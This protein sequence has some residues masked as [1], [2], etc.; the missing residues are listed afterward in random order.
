MEDTTPIEIR[1][2]ASTA[3][4]L[5]RM[6]AVA[7]KSTSEIVARALQ[8]YLRDCSEWPADSF[9]PARVVLDRDSAQRVRKLVESPP[10]P[11]DALRRL[12]GRG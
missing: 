1:V 10:E 6:S 8:I 12:L 5:Q 11:T 2:D 7:G 3:D 4:Q 9:V